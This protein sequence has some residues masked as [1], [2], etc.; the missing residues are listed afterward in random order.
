MAYDAAHPK[1]DKMFV[2]FIPEPFN[3]AFVPAPAQG[4]QGLSF[5]PSKLASPSP[6]SVSP[7][8]FSQITTPAS[9][10]IFSTKGLEA[11]SVAAPDEDSDIEMD[12]GYT[13][14]SEGV[15][16]IGVLAAEHDFP[17]IATL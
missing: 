9:L 4:G 3:G 8:S 13:V 7:A 5:V 1:K 12:D 16:D 2:N 10:P 15:S 6:S 17:P 11:S 14:I